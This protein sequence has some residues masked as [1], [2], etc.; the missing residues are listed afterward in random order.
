MPEPIKAPSWVDALLES[1][2]RDN[3]SVLSDIA[4]LPKDLQIAVLRECVKRMPMLREE[5]QHASGS[6]LYTVACH[7]YSRKLPFEESDVCALLATSR[8]GCGHGS[9]VSPPLDIAQSW[10]QRNGYSEPIMRATREFIG[11]L[12]GVG[13]AQANFAKRRSAIMLLAEPSEAEGSEGGWSKHFRAVLRA[14]TATE[15]AEWQRI[16]FNMKANDVYTPPAVW[17]KHARRLLSGLGHNVTLEHIQRWILIPADPAF[18]TV[19]TGGSHVLKHLVWLIDESSLDPDS[20]LVCD[21]LATRLTAIDWSPTDRASKFM[22]AVANYLKGRPPEVAWEPLQH[23]VRW[24]GGDQGKI[25]DVM[26][27]YGNRYG[28]L[29]HRAPTPPLVAPRLV[30]TR[31]ESPRQSTAAPAATSKPS[32][33]DRIKH[34]LFHD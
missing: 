20:L 16:I 4:A 24:S 21:G 33:I 10:M 13:S 29:R 26:E 34:L 25:P 14:M 18:A 7:L 15:R 32:M 11:S 30:E 23:L 31:Q 19:R 27:E 1:L 8:H 2:P 3:A 12:R 5:K 22:I 28:L 9:D 17:K 6:A